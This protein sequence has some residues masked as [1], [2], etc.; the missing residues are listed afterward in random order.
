MCGFQKIVLHPYAG[1]NIQGCV[2]EAINLSKLCGSDVEFTFNGVHLT[3]NEYSVVDNIIDE[4]G[5]EILS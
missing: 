1:S 3:V 4:Y 5:L 2:T